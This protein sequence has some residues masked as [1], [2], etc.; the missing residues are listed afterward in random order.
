MCATVAKNKIKLHFR[1][2]VLATD[3]TIWRDCQKS[4]SSFSQQMHEAVLKSLTMPYL[5]LFL[6]VSHPNALSSSICWPQL[7]LLSCSILRNLFC[8]T[9]LSYCALSTNDNIFECFVYFLR[10]LLIS[11]S[12]RGSVKFASNTTNILVLV[13]FSVQLSIA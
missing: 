13:G 3:L 11:Y 6:A 12:L 7:A 10:P 5:H 1:G 8:P 4:S 9:H 2:I